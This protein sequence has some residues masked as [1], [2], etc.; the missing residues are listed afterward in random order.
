MLEL[1]QRHIFGGRGDHV[2]IVLCRVLQQKA[3]RYG[4]FCVR[5]RHVRIQ[6]GQHGMYELRGRLLRVEHGRFELRG[7]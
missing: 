7:V 2:H 4:L 5:R 1:H 3:R 6:R